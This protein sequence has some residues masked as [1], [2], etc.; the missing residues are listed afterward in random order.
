MQARHD[1][2]RD[3]YLAASGSFLRPTSRQW[4]AV[5]PR[6][7]KGGRAQVPRARFWFW[8]SL[9]FTKGEG[10]LALN[11]G[12]QPFRQ[13]PRGSERVEPL[14]AR[15]AAV[16]FSRQS[17]VVGWCAQHTEQSVAVF[18]GGAIWKRS[19]CK[20]CSERWGERGVTRLSTGVGTVLSRRVCGLWGLWVWGVSVV[21]RR[22]QRR[23][24]LILQ[25]VLEACESQTCACASGRKLVTDLRVLRC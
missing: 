4:R 6:G 8:P 16:C 11:E 25:G 17:G 21:A 2:Q 7:L 22:A 5:G 12:G 1:K 15:C 3:L 23:R 9:A 20:S 24:W 19:I 14:R 13:P 10:A 18:F